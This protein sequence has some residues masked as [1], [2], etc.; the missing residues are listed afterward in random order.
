[1]L[2]ENTVAA[3]TMSEQDYG[4]GGVMSLL[5]WGEVSKLLHCVSVGVG[6]WPEVL[7]KA[8][9]TSQCCTHH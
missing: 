4:G 7:M 8:Q 6:Q 9:Q 2:A 5:A 1:M 3:S